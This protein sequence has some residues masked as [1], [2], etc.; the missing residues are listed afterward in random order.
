MS[1]VDALK[2]NFLN[3][4]DRELTS[5]QAS[6]LW[7]FEESKKLKDK[8]VVFSNRLRGYFFTSP[9]GATLWGILTSTPGTTPNTFDF[10]TLQWCIFRKKY[11]VAYL[12]PGG[13]L[14]KYNLD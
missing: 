1:Y 5:V 7:H 3:F 9:L 4:K 2:N 6:P 10:L 12:L 13:T 11:M 8:L 14:L